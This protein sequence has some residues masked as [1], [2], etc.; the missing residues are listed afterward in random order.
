[1]RFATGQQ[2]LAGWSDPTCSGSSTHS[3]SSYTAGLTRHTV[4]SA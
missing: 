4:F 2:A 3:T 1:M